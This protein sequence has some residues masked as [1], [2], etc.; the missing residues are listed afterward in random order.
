V[1]APDRHVRYNIDMP[2]GD[3]PGNAQAF[4]DHYRQLARR[5]HRRLSD[6]RLLQDAEVIH[7]L[8]VSIKKIRAILTLVV[9]LDEQAP[10]NEYSS[11]M[12]QIFRPSGKLR[13]TQ[14][15]L[16][17]IDG[18][19]NHGLGPYRQYLERRE[20]KQTRRLIRELK[21]FDMKSLI[22]CD[23]RLDTWLQ[24]IDE[25]FLVDRIQSNIQSRQMLIRSLIPGTADIDNLHRIRINVR[26]LSEMLALLQD[27]QPDT[28]LKAQLDETKSILD[29][30][31]TWHDYDVLLAS[32]FRFID[33][34]PDEV[35][36]Q[37]TARMQELERKLADQKQAA[38]DML[39]HATCFTKPVGND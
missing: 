1:I 21:R 11:L 27:M 33:R 38:V 6:K 10:V 8:R 26:A 29:V 15:N 3:S 12:K 7:K 20:H 28:E 5:L 19:D 4:L 17:L 31:G 32:L 36:L 14:V 9:E 37:T 34:H 2:S 13:E 30:I 23:H 24:G 16:A 35:K 18:I 39:S 22:S 25:Q